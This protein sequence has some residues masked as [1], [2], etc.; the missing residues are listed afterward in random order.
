MSALT[1]RRTMAAA[2]AAAVA[3][4]AGCATEMSQVTPTPA[5]GD[6]R[7]TESPSPTPDPSPSEVD[8]DAPAV[9]GDTYEWSDGLQVTIAPPRP[10][11]PS[12]FF[13]TEAE[14]TGYDESLTYLTFDVTV[15]NST[16]ADYDPAGF[17]TTLQS[18]NVEA[19][20]V[21]VD[22][23]I[24]IEPPPMTTLLP[25]REAAFKLGFGVVDPNDLVM[26]VTPGFEYEGAIFTN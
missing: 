18:T 9:F 15:V 23:G 24:G 11:T 13:V 6:N 21:F 5:V 7:P 22:E 20:Q 26:E 17:F 4:L 25:G 2:A 1:S 8:E 3:L 10:Y 12:E 16:E 19:E 14:I